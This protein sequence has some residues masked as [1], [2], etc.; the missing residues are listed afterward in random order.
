MLIGGEQLTPYQRFQAHIANL[1]SGRTLA[2]SDTLLVGTSQSYLVTAD[3]TSALGGMV[4]SSWLDSFQ[5]NNTSVARAIQ[6]GLASEQAFEA[7]R[8]SGR[9]L[10]ITV[11]GGDVTGYYNSV[12]RNVFSS[13]SASSS[14]GARSL[15][16]I[17]LWDGAQSLRMTPFDGGGPTV[18]NF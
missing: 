2:F 9:Q 3:L 18:Y 4:G 5:G 6:H 13:F 17:L 7:H 14:F 12:W 10:L 16:Q 15:N 11:G 8:V 1:A